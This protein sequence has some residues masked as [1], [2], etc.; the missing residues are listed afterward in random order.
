MRWFKWLTKQMQRRIR[1]Q[2]R[3]MRRRFRHLIVEQYEERRVLALAVDDSYTIPVNETLTVNGYG[4]W[5]NDSYNES[6]SNTYM[7]CTSGEWLP[8]YTEYPVYYEGYYDDFGVWHDDPYWSPPEPIYHPPEWHCLT[9]EEVTT[10]DY[11]S[12]S[13]TSNPSNGTLTQIDSGLGQLGLAFTYTPNSGFSGTDV[14]TYQLYDNYESSTATVSIVVNNAPVANDDYY[15]VAF[16]AILDVAGVGVLAN[17][18]DIDPLTASLVSGPSSGDLTFNSDGSFTYTPNSGTSATSDAFAYSITDGIES[19]SA[20]VNIAISHPQPP[21]ANGDGYTVDEDSLLEIS[22]AAGVLANDTDAENDPLSAAL[23][24][25]PANGTVTLNSDG[26]FTYTPSGNFNGTD[27]FTYVASDSTATS[28]VAIVTISV[29]PVNDAPVAVNDALSADRNTPLTFMPLALLGNDWDVDLNSL[30]MQVTSQPAHGTLAANPDGS[31]VYAPTTEYVGS[32]AFTYSISDGLLAASATANI[33][34]IPTFRVG[35]SMTGAVQTDPLI[36]PPDTMGAVGDHHIVQLL[37]DQYVVIDK[38]TGQVLTQMSDEEFWQTSSG[39]GR[40]NEIQGISLPN[41]A[42]GSFRLGYGANW[43]QIGRD[44]DP[45]TERGYIQ[46]ALDELFGEGNTAVFQIPVPAQYSRVS[47]RIAFIGQLAGADMADLNVV[48]EGNPSAGAAR[49]GIGNELQRIMIYGEVASG[50]FTISVAGNSQQVDWH[51][52]PLI[53]RQRIQTAIEAPTMYGVGTTKVFAISENQFD[54]HFLGTL[55]ETNVANLTVASGLVG[56]IAQVIYAHSGFASFANEVQRLTFDGNVTEGPTSKF[57]LSYGTSLIGEIPYATEAAT[58]RSSIQSALDSTPF[59]GAGRTTVSIAGPNQFDI[60]FIGTLSGANLVPFTV[61]G[62]QLAGT[63]P[64]VNVATIANGTGKE[65]QRLTFDVVDATTTGYFILSYANPFNSADTSNLIY[66]NVSPTALSAS[67]EAELNSEGLFGAGRVVVLPGPMADQF[68]LVFIGPLDGVNVPRLSVGNGLNNP[69]GPQPSV[70]IGH[71]ADGTRSHAARLH[72]SAALGATSGSFTLSFAG[73]SELVPW[74]DEPQS[75]KTNLQ[76]ALNELFGLGNATAHV[77]GATNAGALRFDV[78]FGGLL[79]GTNVDAIGELYVSSSEIQKLTFDTSLSIGFNYFTLTLTLPTTGQTV[80]TDSILYSPNAS[81]LKQVVQ[82][83]LNARI[84]QALNDT[85]GSPNYL[86]VDA[87]SGT[88]ID[89]LF[90][91]SKYTAGAN[92]NQV[93]TDRPGQITVTSP[94]EGGL[95]GRTVVVRSTFALHPEVS[96]LADPRVL[97]DPTSQRWFASAMTKRDRG[98][99][100]LVA[101]SNANDPTAGWKAVRIDPDPF[102]RYFVDFPTLGVD[103]DGVYLGVDLRRGS[104]PVDSLT[105]IS[106]PKSDLLALAPSADHA[107]VIPYLDETSLSLMMQPVFDRS[108]VSDELQTAFGL[109]NLHQL[110]RINFTNTLGPGP[111][112]LSTPEVISVPAFN[113]PVNAPQPYPNI[114]VHTGGFKLHTAV[115]K[116]GNT[117]WLAYAISHDGRAAVRWLRITESGGS[118]DIKEGTISDP[119]L[120]LYY[121]AIAVNAFGDVVIAFSGSSPS[122]YPSAYVVVGSAQ[123]NDVVFGDIELLQQGYG[124]WLG[125]DEGGTLN[126]P[127]DDRYRWG[128]YSAVVPDPDPNTRSFWTFQEYTSANTQWAINVSEINIAA[129]VSQRPPTTDDSFTTNE[130]ASIT[131]N[132]LANDP[133]YAGART[134]SVLRQP[135]HGIVNVNVDGTLTYI[136]HVDFNTPFGFADWFEYQDV[137]ADGNRSR[138]TKVTMTVNPVNDAP[139]LDAITG[140]SPVA[141]DTTAPQTVNLNGIFP[142]SIPIRDESQQSFSILVSSNIPAMFSSLFGVYN[143]NTT[144]TVSY[145]PAANQWGTAT[146]TVTVTDSGGTLNGGQNSISRSFDVTILPVNDAPVASINLAGFS[147][148]EQVLTNLHGQGLSIDDVDAGESEMLVSLQVFHGSL[149]ATAGSSGVLISY[150]LP[151][152]TNVLHLRG[153]KSSINALLGGTSTGTLKYINSSDSPVPDPLWLFV[154][155]EFPG[156]PRSAVTAALLPITPV[157]DAPTVNT[158]LSY[159]ATEQVPLSLSGTMEFW[160]DSGAGNIRLTMSVGYGTLTVVP[161]TV[162][163][164]VESGNGTSTVIVSGQVGDLYQLIAYTQGSLIYEA[165]TNAPPAST[166]LTVTVNDLGNTGIGGALTASATATINIASVNDAPTASIND[167]MIYN[168]TEQVVMNLHGTGIL[169]GDVDSDDIRV[170]VQVLRGELDVSGAA[171]GVAVSYPYAG[172]YNV[173]HFEGTPAAISNLL[174]GTTGQLTYVYASN[175]PFTW[176]TLWVTTIDFEFAAGDSKIINV[177]PV[178]DAPTAYNDAYATNQNTPLNVS[179]PGVLEIDYDPDSESLTALLGI[180]P[181]HGTLTLNSDGSFVYTPDSNYIGTDSFTYRA[182]DGQLDSDLA[183]V[184]ITV[185]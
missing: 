163:V 122:H 53:L 39:T 19:A 114:L 159:S 62:S 91:F 46:A 117:Y 29:Q 98:G 21:V 31:Y 169:V 9:E 181:S 167:Q 82:A 116:Q 124:P 153:T 36:F 83:R 35:R 174:S 11:A 180:G 71:V 93:T 130:D 101:V 7:N 171:T 20:T 48:G 24:S 141:E 135:E 55:A 65:V 50:N 52:D 118:Y 28:N 73:N 64:T 109:N 106:I 113:N 165:N 95:T 18:T 139:T 10:T 149:T 134:V 6:W 60:T 179:G 2:D 1:L 103:K 13:I 102:D 8:E 168:A 45:S 183:T 137:A 155:D 90:H 89:L 138:P 176:D 67:I 148:T 175:N 26:S 104:N 132:V 79:T 157:N 4:T 78:V 162:G 54:V 40:T 133:S 77:V 144:G 97:Y 5:A 94:V 63:A 100:V 61:D 23:V 80:T 158:L 12:S 16:D 43:R 184:V 51:S 38:A 66:W 86:I 120:S 42:T 178:N 41:S 128:D 119:N 147:A 125:L 172:Y 17:D 22:I 44:P 129:P 49:N 110:V 154:Y 146:I 92:I 34:V 164:V 32:D 107:T 173:M 152:F 27:A 142:S 37:N 108:A 76:T 136:P 170:I 156:D 121:P 123:A 59:F 150:P 96:G 74:D 160:D 131:F 33:T 75:L 3:E 127:S 151:N 177:T 57:T 58:L 84:Q 70:G 105:L 85:Q 161:G 166:T 182:R 88:E 68:D 145:I 15:I 99:E 30:S 87:H 14:F 126:D 185:G 25:G 47:Y 69:T 112:T 81:Y 140:P 115:Q 143:G 56:G 111:A 72:L